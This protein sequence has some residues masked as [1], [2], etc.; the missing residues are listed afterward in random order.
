LYKEAYFK[1]G[2]QQYLQGK[3]TNKTWFENGQ[4][5]YLSYGLGRIE[6]NERGNLI[7]KSHF[8]KKKGISG[9]GDLNFSLYAEYY[10]NGDVKQVHFVRDEI[11][12]DGFYTTKK[13]YYWKWDEKKQLKKS[14]E[15]W[16]EPYPWNDF[17]ELKQRL[18]KYELK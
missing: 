18:K 15:N 5:K 7:K 1:N 6:F 17:M 10:K 11:K 16:N 8:W 13:H 12:G 3:D 14:P 4:I 2:Q 9:E